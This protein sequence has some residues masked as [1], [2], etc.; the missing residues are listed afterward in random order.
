MLAHERSLQSRFRGAILGSAVGDALGFPYQDYSRSFMRSL[1][2][3]LTAGFSRHHSGFYPLGQYTDDT[4]MA[5][6]VG[7]AIIEAGGVSGQSM[8]EH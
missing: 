3:S 7:E 4:Q 1:L 6:A 8:A 2:G 5:L